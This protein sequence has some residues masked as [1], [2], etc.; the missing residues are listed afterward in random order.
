MNM[1]STGAFQSEMNASS[2]QPTLAAKFASVW[3]KKNAKAARAGGVSLMALSLAACGSDDTT[4]TTSTATTTTS[5]ATTTTTATTTV[6][7]VSEALKVTNDTVT[8]TTAD[9]SVS[10]VR[11]DG[12]Q[13][14]NSGDSIALGAGTGDAM[15]ANLN[16]GTVSP[17]MTG[18]ESMTFTA[19]G[20]ATVDFVN[21]TGVTSIT[22]NNSSAAL[23]VDNV[24]A[25]APVTISNT[26][27]NTTVVFKTAAASGASDT[28]T[29]NVQDVSAGVITIGSEADAN[30]SFESVVIDATGTN[31]TGNID[32]GATATTLTVTG[33]GSL[34]MNAAAE[35]PALTTLVSTGLTGGLDIALANR[36]AATTTKDLS[37]TTGAGADDVNIRAI[38]DAN[39]DNI[40]VDLG[41][42]DDRLVL[43]ANTD[44]GNSIAGGAGTDILA[45]D[46]AMTSTVA[47]YASGFETLEFIMGGDLTQDMDLVDGMNTVNVNTSGAA[48]N[49]LNI[50]DAAD[51]LVVNL[52]GA[53]L[54]AIDTG[55]SKDITILSI[56]LKTDTANDDV[57]VN[58]NATAG[59]VSV[60]DFLPN[61]SYE[62]VTVT[63]S[64][65]A[66]N[67]IIDVS[68]SLRNMTVTGA[69]AL[70]ITGTGAL[71]G[72]LDATAMT[73]ALTT[74]TG[75]VDLKVLGGSG[76]DT[77]TSGAIAATGAQTL[78][79]GDGD[80]TLTSGQIILTSTL[81][82]LGG[83]GS[84]TI[85][86]ADADGAGG[87][88]ATAIID[89]GTG[90]DFITLET[91]ATVALA[92]VQSTA[93]LSADGDVVDDFTTT[94]D[95][96]DYNGTLKNDA[97]T[98]AGTVSINTTLD[99]ALSGDVDATVYI[100]SGNLSGAASTT[101]GTLADAADTEAFVAAADA[102][103]IALVALEGSISAL[104]S[105]I[106]GT[107]SVLMAFE[108]GT[109]TAVIKFTNSDTSVADTMT[110]AECELV[111][112]FDAA[113]LVAAD[114]I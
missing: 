93:A 79:G 19:L 29:L 45:L 110:A 98:G 39:V 87:K 76:N 58:L 31:V 14:L 46:I 23:T 84:D 3:E 106:Q 69:T 63:S 53:A 21:T 65:A 103:I 25:I 61:A 105:T 2:K 62:T 86:T 81:T 54:A 90:V 26:A 1:I 55:A 51:G 12:V 102:F 56:D 34:D 41:A 108:N 30:G 91:V 112:V 36:A 28:L 70:E 47:T 60:A 57:T 100:D 10:G 67:T 59:A 33:T 66:E 113:V 27:Q 114:F 17:T 82:L 44:T 97:N 72:V 83:A 88:V 13:T 42:G 24:A 77:M 43:D 50:D 68:S 5:T 78:N 75:T 85:N 95:D 74:T 109:D 89:G 104:D 6:T 16:A 48:G 40:T 64:G 18:V 7:A 71:I 96:F 22:N 8:G 11:I 111:A 94:E 9:D 37:V 52:N 101:L 32:F 99:T 35:M 107:E 4:T 73:G 20:A 49:D 38:V 92:D 80:D 15:V